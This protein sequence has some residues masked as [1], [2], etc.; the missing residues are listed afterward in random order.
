MIEIKQAIMTSNK[1]EQILIPPGKYSEVPAF[2]K[3]DKD[4]MHYVNAGYIEGYEPSEAQMKKYQPLTETKERSTVTVY[5]ED[6]K[7]KPA[8]EGQTKEKKVPVVTK[9]DKNRV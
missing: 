5:S 7:E 9:G 2:L 8:T 1:G 4:F 3:K 6:K